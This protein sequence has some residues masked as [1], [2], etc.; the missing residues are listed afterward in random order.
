ME[1]Q[2]LREH[3]VSYDERYVDEDDAAREQMMA[4]THQ[5]GVPV[6]LLEYSDGQKRAFIGFQQPLLEQALKGEKVGDTWGAGT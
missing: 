5:R 4:H 3:Q 6:T 2:F 1:K